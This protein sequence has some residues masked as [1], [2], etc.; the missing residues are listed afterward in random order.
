MDPRA[1]WALI[2]LQ[3][4]ERRKFFPLPLV[5]ARVTRFVLS[6]KKW[7]QKCKSRKFG[8][9]IVSTPRVAVSSLV[10]ISPRG[11][12]RTLATQLASNAHRSTWRMSKCT[13]RVKQIR[14]P[15]CKK[16][17]KHQSPLKGNTRGVIEWKKVKFDVQKFNISTVRLHWPCVVDLNWPVKQLY[18]WAKLWVKGKKFNWTLERNW[19]KVE[20]E[21]ERHWHESGSWNATAPTALSCGTKAHFYLRLKLQFEFQFFSSN[22]LAPSS[23][24]LQRRTQWLLG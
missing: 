5:L 1:S 11:Q 18:H 3:I 10:K 23:S 4:R 20:R 22:F 2:S 17:L 16:R 12:R 14:W 9:L 7:H 15:N 8:P 21:K 13:K 6:F 24:P 19:Q